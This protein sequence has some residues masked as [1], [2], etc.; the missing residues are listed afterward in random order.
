MFP[1]FLSRAPTTTLIIDC[2]QLTVCC[3]SERLHIWF[4][5]SR[6]LRMCLNVFT[7]FLHRAVGKFGIYYE[8]FEKFS[9]TS[10]CLCLHSEKPN[11]MKP[12]WKWRAITEKNVREK[13]DEYSTSFTWSA[14]MFCAWWRRFFVVLT[15]TYERNRK[16]WRKQLCLLFRVRSME[17][18]ISLF[19]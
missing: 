13:S 8:C 18:C 4:E 7:G 10:Q 17:F 9:L 14:T 11:G 5:L 19:F 12:A 2:V 15:R 3:C 6:W 1:M 16:S